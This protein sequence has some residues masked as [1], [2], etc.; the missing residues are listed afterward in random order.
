MRRGSEPVVQVGLME[1]E[2]VDGLLSFQRPVWVRAAQ[3]RMWRNDGHQCDQ[4]AQGQAQAVAHLLAGSKTS[5]LHARRVHHRIHRPLRV[6]VEGPVDLIMLINKIFQQRT[7]RNLP[8]G[9]DGGDVSCSTGTGGAG[10]GRDAG[11]GGAGAERSRM[12]VEKVINS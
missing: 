9:T 7:A 11:G 10:T 12:S 1:S 3:S 6:S 8:P 4:E 2:E 5:S